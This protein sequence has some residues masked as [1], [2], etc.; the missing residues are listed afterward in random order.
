MR[1]L[2]EQTIDSNLADESLEELHNT[3]EMLKPMINSREDAMFGFI[4]GAVVA[5]FSNLHSMILGRKPT[6]Q[7]IDEMGKLLQERSPLI[8]SRVLE[9]L[10]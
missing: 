1:G 9:T 5:T 10:V 4:V 2:I 7:E 6:D 3:F 8:K